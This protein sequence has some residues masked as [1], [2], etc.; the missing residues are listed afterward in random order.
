MFVERRRE[1]VPACTRE[2]ERPRRDQQRDGE[3]PEP[4]HRRETDE[5]GDQKRCGD[6][7]A[8]G[9]DGAARVPQRDRG[10]QRDRAEQGDG[11]PEAG[12]VL[13]VADPLAYRG[14]DRQLEQPRQNPERRA[15]SRPARR[16]SRHSRPRG[17][18]RDAAASMTVVLCDDIR[19]R[20]PRA[21]A[22]TVATTRIARAKGDQGLPADIGDE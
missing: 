20:A 19:G 10:D 4:S 5:G 2:D 11:Q 14:A 8:A 12:G 17:R 16:S 18:S 1:L 6:R 21:H 3:V 15:A 7:D 22:A 9:A 13:R